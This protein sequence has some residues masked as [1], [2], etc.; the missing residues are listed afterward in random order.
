M[1]QSQTLPWR[2]RENIWELFWS[3]QCSALDLSATAPL[4]KVKLGRIGGVAGEWSKL[5]LVRVKVNEN[6]KV[7][8]SSPSL[9]N[10]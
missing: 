10:L 6:Q 1:F 9:G 4:T 3:Y 2:G 8:G 7:P 5:L